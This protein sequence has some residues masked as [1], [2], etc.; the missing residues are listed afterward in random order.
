[1]LLMYLEGLLVS[2]VAEGTRWGNALVKKGLKH[3]DFVAGFDERHEGAQHACCC[4]NHAWRTRR[5]ELCNT[6]S[7]APVVMVISVSGSSLRPQ[8][9]A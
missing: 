9:G 3:N 2:G 5:E 1:M 6:P 8:Y 4:Q 7:L